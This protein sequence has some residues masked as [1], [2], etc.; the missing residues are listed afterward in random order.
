MFVFSVTQSGAIPESHGT[1]LMVLS[2]RAKV[3]KIPEFA[4]S[5]RHRH[6]LKICVPSCGPESRLYPGKNP[7]GKIS[8]QPGIILYG[9]GN[10]VF[11]CFLIDDR[12][13]QGYFKIF[14]ISGMP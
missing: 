12:L 7:G 1:L 11:C 13:V 5:F 8:S 9:N 14:I 10:K 4:K 3:I 6:P 2:G